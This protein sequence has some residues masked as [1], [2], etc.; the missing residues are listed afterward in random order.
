MT[1]FEDG[2]L[3]SL[4]DV[5]DK[6]ALAV[7]PVLVTDVCPGACGPG[8]PDEV[9]V[10]FLT[11]YFVT[12]QSAPPCF[13]IPGSCTYCLHNSYIANRPNDDPPFY[14]GVLQLVRTAYAAN[15]ECDCRFGSSFDC[16]YC[17]GSHV[18]GDI[19]DGPPTECNGR[20]HTGLP[21][22]SGIAYQTGAFC[23]DFTS[24]LSAWVYIVMV[25][26]CPG[27]CLS[28][29]PPVIGCGPECLSPSNPLCDCRQDILFHSVYI[30]LNF[31]TPAFPN[32]SVLGKYFLSSSSIDTLH[33]NLE[34]GAIF[35][36]FSLIIDTDPQP[37]PIP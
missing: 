17:L 30:K 4:E 28:G 22:N 33:P 36:S 31:T 27:Q 1:V 8:H 26:D 18:K 13:G 14:G 34:S 11:T 2:A 23:V 3:I 7:A 9:Y 21:D 37:H 16:C 35:P 20:D 25:A 6:R 32:G 12:T 19:Y 24:G 29:P 5:D 10:H 15:G